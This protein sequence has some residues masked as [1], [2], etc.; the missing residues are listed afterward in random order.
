MIAF[1]LGAGPKSPE[2]FRPIGFG[3][4]LT[5]IYPLTYAPES[6]DIIRASHVLEHFPRKDVLPVMAHWCS[7]LKPGGRLMIAVP[8]LAYIISE[9]L[10]GPSA[11]RFRVIET[12]LMGGQDN[13]SDFHKGTFDE[14]RLKAMMRV[15]GL[16]NIERW[17][18]DLDD[19]A[20]LPVSLNLQGSRRKT[21]HLP[22]GAEPLRAKVRLVQQLDD[23][24]E[25]VTQTVTRSD[26]LPD[27]GNLTVSVID[28]R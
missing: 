28:E 27:I 5:T 12:W 4:E 15:C 6:I 20:A 26:A 23:F 17:Q 18:S 16:V 19:C 21:L 22:E 13:D 8:D 1:D 10:K 3:H 14:W 9:Y 24:P 7:L 25:S 11:A 2:G